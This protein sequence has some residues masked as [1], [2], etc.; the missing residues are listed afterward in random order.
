[1]RPVLQG[2]LLVGA[3]GQTTSASVSGVDPRLFPLR[4]YTLTEGEIITEENLLGRASVAV[5]GPD[6]GA[7]SVRASRWLVGET[8]PH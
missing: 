1:M 7:N 5:I 8:H 3:A 2:S 4:N 6:T